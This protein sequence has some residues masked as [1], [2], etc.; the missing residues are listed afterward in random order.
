MIRPF[1]L[2]VSLVRHTFHKSIQLQRSF[3]RPVDI[4]VHMRLD[5]WVTANPM[6]LALGQYVPKCSASLSL[7]PQAAIEVSL[8]PAI[9]PKGFDP[10]QLKVIH[11]LRH[12]PV[13]PLN[14]RP[15]VFTLPKVS[16][17]VIVIVQQRSHPRRE[18]ELFRVVVEPIPE[19]G[20]R[21]IRSKR[22]GS[23]PE[24]VR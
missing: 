8:S 2:A 23:A 5:R 19:D 22:V 20:F 1:V 11:Q 7:I 24:P 18:A 9:S 3:D 12:R 10:F 17:A 13:N 4:N 14:H 6:S 21:F 16:L 15:K